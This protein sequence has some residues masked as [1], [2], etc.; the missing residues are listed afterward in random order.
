M[1]WFNRKNRTTNPAKGYFFCSINP[2][3]KRDTINKMA[4]SVVQGEK[5][6]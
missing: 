5:A 1:A 4:G 2:E 6:F 3:T